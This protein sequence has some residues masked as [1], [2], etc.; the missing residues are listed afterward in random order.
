M[1][2][3][4][5]PHV[6]FSTTDPWTQTLDRLWAIL[7]ANAL[8]TSLVRPGNRVKLTGPGDGNPLKDNVQEGDL[9]ELYIEPTVETAQFAT[10][11][12][13]VRLAP[14]WSFHLATND[15]RV[16]ARV[17]PV[18]W[19]IL[20]A[21]HDAG[22]HLGLDFVTSA[23]L[24]TGLLSSYDPMENRGTKGW[25]ALLTV[26]VTWDLPKDASGNLQD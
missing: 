20:K 13:S 16:S 25:T 21:L 12:K 24:T 11:S 10:S 3:T 14:S 2:Y 15:M 8:F 5:T 22:E 1:T 17:G 26:T 19:A 18:K 23:R 4:A 6:P 7:E 9:P